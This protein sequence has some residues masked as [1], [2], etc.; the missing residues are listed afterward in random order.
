MIQVDD[1]KTREDCAC[2][3][4]EAARALR[5]RVKV[6]SKPAARKPNELKKEQ[7]EAVLPDNVAGAADGNGGR[8]EL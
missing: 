4:A 7:T 6:G 2:P 3:A 8:N 5:T 1:G